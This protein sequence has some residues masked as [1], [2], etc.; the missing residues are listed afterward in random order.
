MGRFPFWETGS[1]RGNERPECGSQQSLIHEKVTDLFF[2]DVLDQVPQVDR[3]VRIRQR[4]GDQDPAR[5]FGVRGIHRV[6]RS[7]SRWAGAVRHL[8]FS[9][10]W[11]KLSRT[12]SGWTHP[13]SILPS[14]LDQSCATS[15]CPSFGTSRERTGN[16]VRLDSCRMA[17]MGRRGSG[18]AGW[19]SLTPVLR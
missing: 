5:R 7:R 2:L 10:L 18:G 1:L 14:L 17:R 11:P 4:T 3:A 15:P 8:A 12:G 6:R 13:E 16:G 19:L 9:G